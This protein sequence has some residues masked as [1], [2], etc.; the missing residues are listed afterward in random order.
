MLHRNVDKGFQESGL[1][2]FSGAI[3]YVVV[4]YRMIPVLYDSSYGTS[5]YSSSLTWRPGKEGVRLAR[6]LDSFMIF[7]HELIPTLIRDRVSCAACGWTRSSKK[8]R[9]S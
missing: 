8:I 3:Q 2:L 4:Y 9:T 1:S 5:S 7:C 6:C